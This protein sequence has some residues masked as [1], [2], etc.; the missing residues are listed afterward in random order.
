MVFLL[1][2]GK[3]REAKRLA[4]ANFAVQAIGCFAAVMMSLIPVQGETLFAQL[5]R[6]LTPGGFFPGVRSSSGQHLAVAHT[7]YNLLAGAVFLVYPRALFIIVDRFLPVSPAR[8]ELKPFH[9]DRNLL[10]VPSLALR[11][12]AA[13]V[14]YLTEICRKSIAESFDS[15]RYNDLDLSEQVVR[16]EETI[17][18]IHRELSK[19]LVEVCES[20]LSRRDA[21]RLEILHAAASSL[22]R[23][24]E[25]GER[26]RD[27]SARKI[28]EKVPPDPEVDRD[29]NEAYDLVMAQFTNILSLLK[30]RD[31]RTEENAVKMVE[32]L[33][34][35]S[36][37]IESQSRQRIEQSQGEEQSGDHPPAEHGLPGGLPGPLPGRG[38]PR[39][40]R[41]VDAH[42]VAGADLTGRKRVAPRRGQSSVACFTNVARSAAGSLHTPPR[43][44]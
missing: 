1:S 8:E 33:A 42:P 10:T 44:T 11:Q 24:G 23:I 2:V 12:V 14:T 40:H 6:L 15:F 19:Y 7:V 5:V 21:S 35:F 39:A 31:T 37:K 4:F 30:Q 36:S 25:L 26:L 41:A 28:E 9:L 18:E 20:Q 27:V 17:S 16:R 34:K 38:P 43:Q 3:R 32:R 29:M 13:E 22:V